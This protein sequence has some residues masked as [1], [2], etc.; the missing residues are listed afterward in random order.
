MKAADLKPGVTIRG[1]IFPEPV[2]VLVVQAVGEMVKV[3]GAGYWTGS[4]EGN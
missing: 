3:T 2:Q 1:P 4:P